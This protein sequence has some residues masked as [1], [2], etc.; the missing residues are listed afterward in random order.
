MSGKIERHE[1]EKTI[2]CALKRKKERNRYLNQ[3][4]TSSFLLPSWLTD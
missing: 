2:R 3:M 1:E 4:S